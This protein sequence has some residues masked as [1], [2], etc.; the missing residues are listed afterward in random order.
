MYVE[1]VLAKH[2]CIIHYLWQEDY[3]DISARKELRAALNCNSFEWYL[4]NIYP[5]LHI[6]DDTPGSYGAVS[7]L[8]ELRKL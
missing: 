4:Q 2:T 5:D 8:F 3:G 7:I 1:P 6:P